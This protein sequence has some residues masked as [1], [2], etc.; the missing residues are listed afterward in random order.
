MS[1][2]FPRAPSQAQW[3]A[4]SEQE[5]A[6]VVDSLPGEVTDAELSPPEGDF[7]MD[8]KV[9]ALGTLKGHFRRARCR[10]Y[11]ASELPV[12]YPA[13]RRFAPDLLAVVDVETHRR[14]KWVVSA[15][16]KGLDF[17]LE[18]HADGDRKKDAQ[19]NVAR[20]A[21]LGIPEYFVYDAHKHLL[22]GWR[23]P[24]ARAREYKRMV[25]RKGRIR[26]K[27]LGLELTVEQERLCFYAGT[28]KLLGPEELAAHFEHQRD[29]AEQQI[30]K[31]RAEL[32]RLR[33]RPR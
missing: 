27:R 20:Y 23:L 26:S 1:D 19:R 11:V 4:M 2:D 3:E 28:L 32:A 6:Q 16:G 7:H 9:E 33:A 22:E 24:S 30:A 21:R 31:L 18:V 29:L 12:Y 17:V 25:P 5:R 13:E 14:N 15:E 8:A 10:V